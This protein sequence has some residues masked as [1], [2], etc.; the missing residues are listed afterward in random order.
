MNAPL[1]GRYKIVIELGRGSY[2]ITYKVEDILFKNK[3]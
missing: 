1:N 2:G 3:E